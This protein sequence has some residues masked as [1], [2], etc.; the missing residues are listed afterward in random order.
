MAFVNIRKSGKHKVEPNVR[1]NHDYDNVGMNGDTIK[2]EG[3]L[4]SICLSTVI[5]IVVV[6]AIIL[7]LIF[8]G[9]NISGFKFDLFTRLDEY[10]LADYNG[11]IRRSYIMLSVALVVVC[12]IFKVIINNAVRGRFRKKYLKKLYI[13]I[14][15]GILV[16]INICLYL[17]IA[18]FFFYLVNEI[19]DVIQ[20]STFIEEVNKETINLFKYIVVIVITIFG[21]LNSFTG[22]SI[23]HNKNKFVLED[24]FVN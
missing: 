20:I 10:T 22:I 8:V 18:F 13:Y 11:A 12:F 9:L 5:E 24:F 16:L 7:A 23:V 15:D 19:Y 14:Y 6:L 3:N 2:S 4:A 17:L 21:V 1:I